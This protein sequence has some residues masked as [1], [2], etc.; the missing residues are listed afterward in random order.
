MAVAELSTDSLGRLLGVLASRPGPLPKYRYASAGTLYPVQAYLSLPAPGLPGLPPGCHYHDPEAHALAPV[1][2]RPAGDA[3]LLLLV[4]QMA[5]IEPVYSALSEDFCML[6]AGYMTAALEDAAAEA[7]LALAD[8]G[9]PAGW[10]RA[11]LDACLA[12]E[13]TH[14]PLLA[15]RVTAA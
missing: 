7:G 14:Q 8:A 13:A 10:D 15:L 3:A 1:S 4:A 2:D 5:A 9:D 11:A 12:L 6:E